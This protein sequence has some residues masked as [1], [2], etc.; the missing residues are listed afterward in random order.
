MDPVDDGCLNLTIYSHCTPGFV[1]GV[2]VAFFREL[3]LK[4]GGATGPE[5]QVGGNKLVSTTD[6]LCKTFH[7]SPACSLL[8]LAN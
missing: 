1:A 7:S 5:S 6:F 4:S 8:Y 3:E 2:I